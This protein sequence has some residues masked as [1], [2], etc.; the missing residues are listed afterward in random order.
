MTET[1]SLNDETI[2][3]QLAYRGLTIIGYYAGQGDDFISS[4]GIKFSYDGLPGQ[5]RCI[6]FAPLF[7]GTLSVSFHSGRTA[8]RSLHIGHAVD[9]TVTEIAM[10]TA[11]SEDVTVNAV[12]HVGE[13]Y[14][15]WMEGGGSAY[16]TSLRYQG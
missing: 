16:I 2:I 5:Y 4:E 7:D 1:I 10:G 13:V 8:Q 9:D 15:I 3:P 14:Y 12:L 6:R 11:S